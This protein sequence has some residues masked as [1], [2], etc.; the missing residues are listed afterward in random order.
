MVGEQCV[1]LVSSNERG[2]SFHGI[3]LHGRSAPPLDVNAK[4]SLPPTTAYKIR[5]SLLVLWGVCIRSRGFCRRILLVYDKPFFRLSSDETCKAIIS[6]TTNQYTHSE[7]NC[8]LQ[9]F[10]RK[11]YPDASEHLLDRLQR[12]ALKVLS[13]HA[14]AGLRT[15]IEANFDACFLSAAGCCNKKG[16]WGGPHS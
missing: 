8:F 14:N 5:H 9:G 6:T 16:E 12:S 7:G 2:A 15:Y 11:S 10:S 3:S 1:R 13:Q 4:L